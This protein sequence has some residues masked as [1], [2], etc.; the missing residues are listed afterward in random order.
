M[1][2]IKAAVLV[3]SPIEINA[4]ILCFQRKDH[5][6]LAEKERRDY[7]KSDS[8]DLH[9]E[10]CSDLMWFDSDMSQFDPESMDTFMEYEDEDY[11]PWLPAHFCQ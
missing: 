10:D 1:E 8:I 2:D 7:M 5:K 6:I 4:N 3:S 9:A 11:F